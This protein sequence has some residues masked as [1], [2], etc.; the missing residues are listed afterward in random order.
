M[1]SVSV[2]IQGDSCLSTLSLRPLILE[3]VTCFM[4]NKN[5]PMK[6][7]PILNGWGDI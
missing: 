2:I 6:H 7:S 1:K 3:V 5:D 4:W